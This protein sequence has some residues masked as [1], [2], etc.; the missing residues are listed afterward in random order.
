MKN[1]RNAA[2]RN[3]LTQLVLI[4]LALSFAAP[5]LWMISTSLTDNS[6][7]IH[8]SSML[9]PNPVHWR[10]Y[11]DAFTRISFPRMFSNTLIVTIFSTL[12][13]LIV[14]PLAAYSSG[15]AGLAGEGVDLRAD[16]ECNDDSRASDDDP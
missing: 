15:Q 10:N 8:G 6:Q 2:A 9:D 7:F 4:A 1:H 3:L 12:G 14:S 5:L 16:C 13:M 11:F